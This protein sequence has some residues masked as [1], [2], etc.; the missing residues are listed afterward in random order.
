M[1]RGELWWANL[2]QP[3]GPSPVILISRDRA[4][5]VRDAVT[6]AQVTSTI[7]KIPVEVEVGKDEGLDH[8]SVI[9]CDVLLTI[10]KRLLERRLG[11][12]PAAKRQ[13]L[14]SALRFALGL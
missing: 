12:L 1:Q 10:P 13:A 8:A 5:Q 6:V 4:I 14:D 9:N 3:V 11:I 7:R 2:P